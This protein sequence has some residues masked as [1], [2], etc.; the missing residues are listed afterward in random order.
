MLERPC[1]FNTLIMNDQRM[2]DFGGTGSV[3][4]PLALDATQYESPTSPTATAISDTAANDGTAL[5]DNQVQNGGMTAALDTVVIGVGDTID[6]GTYEIFARVR[7]TVDVGPSTSAGRVY[8]KTYPKSYTHTSSGASAYRVALAI[9][10]QAKTEV[11]FSSK[12]YTQVSLQAWS[13]LESDVVTLRLYRLSSGQGAGIVDDVTFNPSGGR[14]IGYYIKVPKIDGLW[15]SEKRDERQNV[16]GRKGELSG[17]IE[18]GGKTIT[19]AGT[20]RGKDV[21]GLRQG[22]R[23]LQAAF[24]D[25]AAHAFRFQSW[26]DDQPLEIMCRKNQ[27]LDMAE[28]QTSLRWERSFTVQLRADDPRAYSVVSQTSILTVGAGDTANNAGTDETHPQTRIYGSMRNPVLTNLTTGEHLAWTDLDIADG[29]YVLID[30]YTGT[31]TLNGVQ[32]LYAGLDVVESDFFALIPGDNQL[33][34]SAFSFGVNARAEVSWR[35]AFG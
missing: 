18:D 17:I 26:I 25:K 6:P 10:G 19:L 20:I 35:S 11:Q 9:N 13:L 24:A 29:D 12:S 34:I 23:D 3:Q 5:K 28:E 14:G 15:D 32:P 4:T 30:H 2:Y 8:P 31:V 21:T 7:G 33:V 1:S 22:Q 27:R 16:P